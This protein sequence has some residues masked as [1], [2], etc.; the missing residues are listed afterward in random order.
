MKIKKKVVAFIGTLAVA[1]ALSFG[2]A[3]TASAFSDSVTEKI[4]QLPGNSIQSNIW[5]SATSFNQKQ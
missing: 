2:G 3:D 4:P 1:G 5:M